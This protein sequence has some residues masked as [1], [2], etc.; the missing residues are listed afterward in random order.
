MIFKPI[1]KTNRID[2]LFALPATTFKLPVVLFLNAWPCN[3]PLYTS[4][5][6]ISFLF[7]YPL[8]PK[9]G[10]RAAIVLRISSMIANL[11]KESIFFKSRF[12]GLGVK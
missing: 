8:P 4:I 2:N 6:C 10:S 3:Y 7:I 5:G 11:R 9:G 12:A 1:V